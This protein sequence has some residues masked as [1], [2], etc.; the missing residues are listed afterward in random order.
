MMKLA[1][2][3]GIHFQMVAWHQLKDCPQLYW[4]YIEKD[5]EGIEYLF[6]DEYDLADTESN[7]YLHELS[8]LGIMIVA[9]SQ[10]ELTNQISECL[11]SSFRI[12]RCSYKPKEVAHA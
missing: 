9:A 10:T 7:F 8:L 12:T 11:P 1:E 5:V 6:I 2:M 4:K 3:R